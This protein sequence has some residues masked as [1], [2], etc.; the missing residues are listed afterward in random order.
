VGPTRDSHQKN[1]RPYP[2]PPRAPPSRPLPS[3]HRTRP[4]RRIRRGQGWRRRAPPPEDLPTHRRTSIRPT[5]SPPRRSAPHAVAPPTTAA[6]RSGPATVSAHRS[7]PP[8]AAADRSRPVTSPL[9]M[10]G[11]SGEACRR[12]RTESR[13]R[14]IRD[15]RRRN[16]AFARQTRAVAQRWVVGRRRCVVLWWP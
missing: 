5:H 7:A 1:L 8:T 10:E 6:H 11:T 9:P 12:G 4:P 13:M 2:H 14:R 16:E 15:R 3:A